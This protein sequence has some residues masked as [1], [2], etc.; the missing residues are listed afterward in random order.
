MKNKSTL[1]G[2]TVARK[3]FLE[4]VTGAAVFSPDVK[5]DGMLYARLLGSTIAHGYIKRID[6]SKAEALPGVVAVITGKDWPDKRHGYILDRH[7]IC[8]HK[9]RYYGDPVAAVA[10]TSPRIAEQALDLI[11][12]EYEEIKPVFNVAEAF[13]ELCPVVVHDDL[14]NYERRHIPGVI[15]RFVPD[16]PNVFIHRKIR[17]GDINEGFAQADLIY[18]GTYTLPLVHTCTMETH[19][20][21]VAPN[22]DGSMTI[23]ASEQGGVRLK[24]FI[25][26][27]FHLDSSKVRFI[28]PYLGGGFGGKTDTMTTPIAVALAMKA[29]K[30]VRLTLSREE[31]FLHGNP[32]S[33]AVVY[34]RDGMKKDGT[35]VAREI[36]T[37]INGGAYSGHCACLCNDGAYGATGSYRCP[38]F[39]LDIF[40]VHTNTPPT[41]PYRS[42]GSEILGFAI[43]CHIDRMAEKFGLDKVDVRRKNVLV[44]GDIDVNGQVTKNNQTLAALNKAAEF[45]KWGEK[46]EPLKAPWVIGRGIAVGNKFSMNGSTSSIIVKVHDDGCVEVRHYHIELGQGCNTVHAL[47]AAE[48]FGISPEK[49]K[50]VFDD[51]DICG[52]DHGTFC[53]RGTYMN[54]N[55]CIKACEDAKRNLLKR[56]SDVM[57]IS[58]HLL[59]T[60]GGYV[61]EIANPEN[62]KSFKELYNY[63]GWIPDI[64]EITGKATFSLPEGHMD[65][66][67][68]QGNPVAEYS[69]GALGVEVAVNKET[70]E[71]KVLKAGGWYDAGQILNQKA[72][73]GQIEGAVSMGIGQA[74]FEEMLWNNKGK[75]VNASFRDYKVPT[76][77]DSTFNEGVAVGFVG[78]YVP[79]GP[80]GAKGIGEVA[81]AP[82]IPAVANAINDALGVKINDIPMSKE[83][84]FYAIKEQLK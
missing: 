84:V 29:R 72:I 1:I 20:T 23:W 63:G 68:G 75:V 48:Q 11:E 73:E 33:Q 31:C 58:E 82:V 78:E 38:H 22:I 8:K 39:K 10:A 71:I 47:I 36:K 2:T 6:T 80:Y 64:V 49:V 35:L 61:F 30:P 66:E 52:F 55:A 56:A 53:S 4:K 5:P 41:G 65:P 79:G 9:V 57:G 54:G 46:V 18:E 43:E 28:T 83:R 14:M 12:V 81:L 13:E 69:Y 67:T 42:L 51:S 45:L 34:I 74:V 59:D 70:G 25:C 37:L 16:R 50:I 40:G 62:K 15:W 44:N 76:M 26:D 24:Y 60:Y 77:L 19:T 27:L 21:C 17:H 32:R 3:D 7:I